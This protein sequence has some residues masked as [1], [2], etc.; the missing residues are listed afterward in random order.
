MYEAA[1]KLRALPSASSAFLTALSGYN[2]DKAREEAKRAGFD[3][4]MVKPPDM[5]L[6]K[7][8]LLTRL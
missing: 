3:E 6:I 8:W 7:Q 5:S 2:S 1:R 4:Y